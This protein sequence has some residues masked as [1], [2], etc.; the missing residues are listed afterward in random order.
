M[1]LSARP[2]INIPETGS[3]L[4]TS[5]YAEALHTDSTQIMGVV[6][7]SIIA[8]CVTLLV[9]NRITANANTE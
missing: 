5:R 1:Y 3:V 4:R 8:T 6:S 7:L 9:L 2:A